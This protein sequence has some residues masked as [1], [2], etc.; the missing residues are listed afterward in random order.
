MS[1]SRINRILMGLVIAV[2]IIWLVIPFSM[3]ILWSLV[4]PSEPWTAGTCF[5]PRCLFIAG[6]TCGRIPRSNRR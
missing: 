6:S 5:P 4:D 2:S 3:A 1:Q